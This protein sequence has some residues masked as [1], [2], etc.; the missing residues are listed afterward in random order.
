MQSVRKSKE[1]R[2]KLQEANVKRKQAL[3]EEL[4]RKS[5]AGMAKHAEQTVQKANLNT[6]AAVNEDGDDDQRGSF[7]LSTP[8]DL[9]IR[10]I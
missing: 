6:D 2:R 3:K 4:R 8:M 9:G 10:A 5:L 1:Q 7:K